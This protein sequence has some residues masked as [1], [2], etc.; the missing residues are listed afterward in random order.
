MACGSQSYHPSKPLKHNSGCAC[1]FW[2]PRYASCRHGHGVAPPARPWASSPRGGGL[3]SSVVRAAWSLARWM[4]ILLNQT[5]G[6]LYFH[7]MCSSEGLESTRWN[8]S[9]GSGKHLGMRRKERQHSKG[10]IHFHLDLRPGIW[11]HLPP[12]L[13]IDPGT[14]P[15]I[16]A[17]GLARGRGTPSSSLAP[18]FMGNI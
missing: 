11:D 15:L 13:G 16:R 9:H 10:R 1:T 8:T 5:G 7:V 4:T 3:V 12:G 18:C 17:P 2:C 6:E 14:K